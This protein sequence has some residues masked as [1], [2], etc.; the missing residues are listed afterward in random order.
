M[1][2]YSFDF[3]FK[4]V[5]N[6]NFLMLACIILDCELGQIFHTSTGPV[7]LLRIG[8]YLILFLHLPMVVN[9]FVRIKG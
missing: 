5:G 4:L 7:E 9:H 1:V 8:K 3:G 2:Y 6:R